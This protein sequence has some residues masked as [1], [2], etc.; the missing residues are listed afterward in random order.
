MPPQ[1]LEQLPQQLEQ[2]PQQLEQQIAVAVPVVRPRS[3]RRAS[4]EARAW[5]TN[6]I[7][8]GGVGPV[9]RP[10]RR[11]GQGQG[12]GQVLFGGVDNEDLQEDLQPQE[13]VAQEEVAQ[14]EVAQGEVAQ[15]EVA[16]V[17]VAQVEVAQGEVAQGEV[18]QVEVAQ[19]EEDIGGSGESPGS[20]DDQQEMQPDIEKELEETKEKLEEAK[21]PLFRLFLSRAY[22]LCSVL[23]AILEGL[24]IEHEP[25]DISKL[26]ELCVD[27]ML[28]KWGFQHVDRPLFD[29]AQK[30]LLNECMGEFVSL[31]ESERK[32]HLK[33]SVNNEA[34]RPA[35]GLRFGLQTYNHWQ[36]L[37]TKY[38][39][40]IKEKHRLMQHSSC[41]N[42][43]F[44]L[45]FKLILSIETSEPSL[46]LIHGLCYFSV[47]S[48]CFYE[49]LEFE[50]MDSYCNLWALIQHPLHKLRV[51]FQVKEYAY[52][53]CEVHSDG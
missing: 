41:F 51:S 39:G 38:E 24:P 25:M 36:H 18:A 34:D 28:T 37:V 35:F 3:E 42:L 7:K 47:N 2:L 31:V 5:I 15:G 12:Q 48:P 1:Q 44:N 11:R 40:L 17:E 4:I 26:E 10:P 53:G 16:Q 29:A 9:R 46:S 23:Q 22:S 13:E 14:E 30:Q 52:G 33:V 8:S 45:S 50:L 21:G 19:E 43:R 20:I 32:L 49:K 6:V 27:N